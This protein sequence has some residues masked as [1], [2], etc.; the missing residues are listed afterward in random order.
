MVAAYQNITTTLLSE[1]FPLKTI[2]NSDQDKLWFNEQLQ[3][4]KR[5]RLREYEK[6]GQSDKY[7]EIVDSFNQMFKTERDKYF[8]KMRLEVIEGERGS[9]YPILKKLSLRPGESPN[10]GFELP[11]HAGLS[12]AQAAEI[13]ATHFSSISQEYSP[14]DVANLPPNVRAWLGTNDQTLQPSLS[15]REVEKKQDLVFSVKLH[16]KS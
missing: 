6:H 5:K 8:Q 3:R 13:I 4:I 9:I 11:E 10:C 16:F 2:I 15:V 1:I 7:W 14:L 12:Q